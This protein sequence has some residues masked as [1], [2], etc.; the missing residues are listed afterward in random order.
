MFRT[1]RRV[2]ANSTRTGNNAAVAARPFLEVGR[3]RTRHRAGYRNGA[4]TQPVVNDDAK[5][6]KPE[7][8]WAKY[9]FVP[10]EKIFFEDNQEG[11]ENGEF[12]S[13]WDI[14]SGNVENAKLGNDKVIMF[15]ADSYIMPYLDNPEQDYL[16]DIFTLEF[17]CYFSLEENY[18][19]YFVYFY[20]KK[21]QEYIRELA[22]IRIYWNMV[23]YG[24]FKGYYPG[25]SNSQ[26][27][28]L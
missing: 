20:D 16:P 14:Q 9:D 27:S 21:N 23:K 2:F 12:P 6:E 28:K 17:D 5:N 25:L 3:K 18:Q 1:V 8:T 4:Q 13:R 19:D 24:D 22:D 26:Y 11:E 15:R 10:G 7:L